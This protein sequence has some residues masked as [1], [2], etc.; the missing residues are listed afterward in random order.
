MKKIVLYSVV[1]IGAFFSCNKD[2]FY[3]KSDAKLKFSSSMVTFDTI[4]TTVS[5]ITKRLIVKNPYSADLLTDIYLVGDNNSYFSININGVSAKSLT[6]VKV[7]AKDSIFIFVKVILNPNQVNTP[8]LVTDTIRFITNGNKQNVEL[9]A[10]G[11]DAHFIIADRTLGSLKYKIVA[12]EGETTTWTND[13]PY[14][15][16][17]Y[18]VVDSVGKLII[19]PGTKIYIHKK[20]GL[21]IYKGGCL[22][23]NG[24][25][26]E[27]VVFQGDRLEEFFQDDYEQWDR[28]WINEGS[29]DNSIN[30]AIIKNAFIGIQAEVLDNDM[31]NKLILTNSIIKKSA[32]IGFLAKNY[33]VEAYNNV[34][35]DC[36]QHCLALLQG[37]DYT[38]IN[39]TLHNAYN[40]ETR[41]T[42]SV[43]FSNYY[44]Y[45][46][47]MYLSDFECVFLNNIIWGSNKREFSCDYTKSAI[48]KTT[49]KYCLLK[50]DTTYPDYFSSVI[51]NKNPLFEDVTKYDYQ[52]QS[53][54][55]CKGA[56]Q[57]T[58]SV[59]T[60]IKGTTRQSPPSIGAY[61]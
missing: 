38:F 8:M 5:S 22:H 39:N 47:T 9:L 44:V 45:N 35:S 7:P 18:A 32:G 13:K 33:V 29:Q 20:G 52:L 28:I 61:E 1:L 34:I 11:Q 51:L 14:V 36:G 15:I 24:T 17:G 41:N 19:E 4:F 43:F 40:I 58:S 53:S 46:N 42:P 54:S 21:W 12:Q 23:V 50:S 16:Y 31:G 30:Y 27:P 59:L 60:D 57:T 3:E 55:P 25:M 48:F 2:N 26:D 49:I 10:C 56:G 6:D 37:G